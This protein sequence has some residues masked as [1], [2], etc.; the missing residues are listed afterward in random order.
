MTIYLAYLAKPAYGGWISYTA[1]LAHGL[2][3]LGHNVM[4]L[5]IAKR[6]ESRCRPLGRG[7]WYQNV[8]TDALASMCRHSPVWITAVDAAHHQAAAIALRAGA[9]LT[10]HD[11]TELK[12]GLVNHIRPERTVVVRTIMLSHIAG[13]TYIPHP[14]KRAPH[15]DRVNAQPRKSA[16]TLHRLDFDKHCDLVVQANCRPGNK[17]DIYGHA[18]TLYTHIKLDPID[19]SWRRYYYGSFG[20]EDLHAAVAIARQY[21]VLV[22]M[23][24]IKGDGQG[25]QYTFLEALDAGCSLLLHDNWHPSAQ[26]ALCARTVSDADGLH[27][28]VQDSPPHIAD[29]AASLLQQ[30]DADRIA[31][32]YVDYLHR[33]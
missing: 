20:T 3:S 16:C 8:T 23:S 25:T 4:L 21:H 29:A 14:Y 27:R 1:H 13:A 26:V 5:K 30:H 28:A 15:E 33:G 7:L 17:I 24:V 12:K 18:N 9:H 6:T 2:Q 32:I 11:P 19:A 22:D 31:Q 10:I